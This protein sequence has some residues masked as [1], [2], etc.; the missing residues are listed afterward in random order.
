MSFHQPH[1]RRRAHFVARSIDHNNMFFVWLASC[2]DHGY[3][4]NLDWMS[5]IAL[6]LSNRYFLSISNPQ[7]PRATGQPNTIT[8]GKKEGKK[9]AGSN[10]DKA[11]VAV[12][13]TAKFA[14]FDMPGVTQPD[15]SSKA[16]KQSKDGLQGRRAKA[17]SGPRMDAEG[18]KF[19]GGDSFVTRTAN[20]EWLKTRVSVY[21]KVKQRR[22]EEMKSKTPVE[23]A[24]T[25]P[26]G[27]VLTQDKNG[28]PFQAWKT[29]PYDVA[30]TI[31]QGLADAVTVARVTYQS[32][33]P[34]YSP[35]EDGMEGEDTLMD[36]MNDGG[37][38]QESASSEKTFLWD[39]QRNLVGNVSKLELLKF[40]DDKDAKTTFWHS[41][42]HMMGEA[43]EHSFGSKLTIG[44]P[45]EGGFYY[46]SFMGTDALREE[47]CTYW[48]GVEYV[49]FVIFSTHTHTYLF[50][51]GRI[52]CHQTNLS[53]KKLTKS[54]SKSRNLNVWSSPKKKD[55]SSLRITHSRWKFSRRK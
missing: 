1:F 39:L 5:F 48:L 30:V 38:E 18:G 21:D 32:F 35:F 50:L 22:D 3:L 40:E 24:V 51:A 55:W 45:L 2:E 14:V 37:I 36:A 25:M 53:R 11:G 7:K 17:S 44:P 34:D 41:S 23:I 27:K 46:D 52:G 9:A 47:D 29:T 28:V 8:M 13:K 20:P 19:I 6:T 43:L 26:D 15:L 42:A 16:T 31:S 54:S 4:T 12:N 49:H 33:V 10:D